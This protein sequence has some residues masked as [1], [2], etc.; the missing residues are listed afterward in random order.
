MGW[1]DIGVYGNNFY[2]TPNIDALAEIGS[3]QLFDLRDDPGE[4]INLV[5]REPEK[6]KS[7]LAELHA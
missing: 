6:A 4:Q 7:L 2:V 3:I 5:K 1:S